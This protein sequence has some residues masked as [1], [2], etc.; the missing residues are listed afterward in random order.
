MRNVDFLCLEGWAKRPTTSER[1]AGAREN[2]QTE[3]SHA[4]DLLARR[5]TVIIYQ[6]SGDV[7]ESIGQAYGRSF[8]SLWSV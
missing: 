6:K 7:A 2:E 8:N 5:N 3:Y 4:A 1:A